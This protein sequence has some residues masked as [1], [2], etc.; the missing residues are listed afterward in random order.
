MHQQSSRRMLLLVRLQRP[1]CCCDVGI[2]IAG[3][4]TRPSSFSSRVVGTR[5]RKRRTVKEKMPATILFQ[6][7]LFRHRCSRVPLSFLRVTFFLS[8]Q[9]LFFGRHDDGDMKSS[10]KASISITGVQSTRIGLKETEES[11][12]FTRLICKKLYE[13]VLFLQSYD[14]N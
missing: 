10:D 6:N 12:A 2:E 1:T 8:R 11:K 13:L 4:R 5:R 9:L 3:R 14:V 7:V